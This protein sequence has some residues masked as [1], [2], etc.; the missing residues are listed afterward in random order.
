MSAPCSRVRPKEIAMNQEELRKKLGQI[1][2]KTWV[3][4][5]FKKK[6]LSDP[7]AAMKAEGLAIPTG[8]AVEFAENTDK[9][10]HMVLPPKPTGELSDAHLDTVSGGPIYMDKYLVSSTINQG[11]Q[12]SWSCV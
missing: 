10:F 5:A 9:E 2:A 3:D 6:V 4:D 1:I 12:V 7:A 8:M 11:S